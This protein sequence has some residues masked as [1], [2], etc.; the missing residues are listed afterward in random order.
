M[1]RAVTRKAR[2]KRAPPLQTTTATAMHHACS[3]MIATAISALEWQADDNNN[4]KIDHVIHYC[5][6]ELTPN[7]SALCAIVLPWG[8]Y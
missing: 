4:S 7:L 5:L 3:A 6:S 8:K 2:L 1:L